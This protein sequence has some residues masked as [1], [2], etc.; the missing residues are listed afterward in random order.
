MR[1]RVVEKE[2]GMDDTT[3]TD[4]VLLYLMKCL[5]REHTSVTF[6]PRKENVPSLKFASSSCCRAFTLAADPGTL[7]IPSSCIPHPS[8]YRSI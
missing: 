3:V 7:R 5:S 1:G 2:R 4:W 8:R 6:L